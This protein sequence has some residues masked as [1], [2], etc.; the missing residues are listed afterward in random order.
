MATPGMPLSARARAALGLLVLL[1]CPRSWPQAADA[2]LGRQQWRP[3]LT[4]RVLDRSLQL[5]RRFLLNNQRAEGNFEY[6]YDL[7]ER[8]YAKMDSQVRQAGALWGLALIH[9]DMPTNETAMAVER[10]LAFFRAGSVKRDDGCR[11]PVYPEAGEGKTGVA[12][13]LCLALIDFLRAEPRLEPSRLEQHRQDLRQYLNFLVSLRQ[14]NGLF[15][16][17]YDLRTGAPLGAPSPYSDGEALL[18]LVK[19]AKYLGYDK[20]APLAL[21]SAA[22]MH[23]ANVVTALAED[24]DSAVTK[25]FYQWG[26]MAYY[27]IAASE[28]EGTAIY[29]RHTVALAYWMIDVHRTLQ[30]QRNTAYALEG[31]AVAWELARRQKDYRAMNKIGYAID[32]G[33]N[34]LTGWQ[35]SG[36]QPNAFLRQPRP[37]DP[38]AVGGVLNH[39]SEPILRIDVAQH[40]M[41]AVILARR[42]IYR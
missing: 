15:H 14:A 12:A 13:L 24:P 1:A 8:R 21:G 6:Q 40:Q 33:L 36:P 3:L 22:G 32:Q 4:R 7:A 34:K 31:M 18:A 20:L 19:A 25:G 26:S 28:W 2:D 29:A 10:G 16:G 35:V 38:K 30:R 41:H 27:E 11:Y 9:H 17:G 39:A 23:R 42:F 5:G 37:P